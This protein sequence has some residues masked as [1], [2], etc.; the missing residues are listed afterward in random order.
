M[1]NNHISRHVR[2]VLCLFLL[3]MVV[4]CFVGCGGGA[5]GLTANEVHRRHVDTLKTSRLQ[6]QDDVDAFFLIDRPSRLSDKI[7]R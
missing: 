7:T 3:S 2:L 5:P 4:S 6:W 1:T